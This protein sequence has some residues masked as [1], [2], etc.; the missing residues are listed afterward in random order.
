MA[1]MSLAPDIMNLTVVITVAG[2]AA[3]GWAL[4]G[5]PGAAFPQSPPERA[6]AGASAAAVDIRVA[7]VAGV[8]EWSWAVATSTTPGRDTKG[9]KHFFF[10]KKK[11]KTFAFLLGVW[12]SSE[13][14]SQKVFGSFFQKRTFGCLIRISDY[15]RKFYPCGF[16]P[17]L[18]ELRT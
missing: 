13:P 16:D 11:Q 3:I 15:R 5:M 18:H 7:A 14:N 2:V 10:E 1:V 9:R 12:R 17:A 8:A 6:A 4:C